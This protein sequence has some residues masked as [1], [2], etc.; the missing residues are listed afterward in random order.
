M[1]NEQIQYLR[2]IQ[3]L[4]ND[5]AKVASRSTDEVE[6]LKGA[7]RALTLIEV[8][9]RLKEK[10]TQISTTNLDL[11]QSQLNKIRADLVADEDDYKDTQLVRGVDLMTAPY[12]P[13]VITTTAVQ[14]LESTYIMAT[15]I[16][17]DTISGRAD[18]LKQHL[19]VL[20]WNN[21]H[22]RYESDVQAAIDRYKT[23]YYDRPL[24]EW[25]AMPVLK[26]SLFDEHCF[27]AKCL[28]SGYAKYHEKQ[29][30]EIAE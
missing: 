1:T 23:L 3:K 5:S 11:L 24:H 29:F 4:I 2:S 6:K 25:Q 16:N 18:F 15:S 20:I 7:E 30:K 28:Y 21:G 27:E 13:S 26:P 12:D 8:L 19:R 10:Y 17:I 22:G 14:V 9:R